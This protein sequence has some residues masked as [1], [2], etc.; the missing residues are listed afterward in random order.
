VS[1]K[2][3]QTCTLDA[4]IHERLLLRQAQGL[5]GAAIHRDLTA[6]FSGRAPSRNTVYNELQ[7]H[8]R[9]DSGTWS[10]ADDDAFSADDAR[11]VLDE[12]R[13]VAELTRGRVRHF[14]SREAWWIAR[15][16][17]VRPELA[18]GTAYYLARW[19]VY[20]ERQGHALSAYWSLT[21]VAGDLSYA[22]S[23]DN[24]ERAFAT[25]DRK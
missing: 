6:A 14:T 9:D 16:R 1:T 5:A 7:R 21:E 12:L 15:L 20:S 18:P 2:T 11:T 4:D 3:S 8:R 25:R 24:P 13:A 19:H 22:L 17:A 10:L 23:D